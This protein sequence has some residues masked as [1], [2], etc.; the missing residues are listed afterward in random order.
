MWN[1][2]GLNQRSDLLLHFNELL[3]VTIPIAKLLYDKSHC[4]NHNVYNISLHPWKKMATNLSLIYFAYECVHWKKPKNVF[5]PK[6]NI[7]NLKLT[8]YKKKYTRCRGQMAVEDKKVDI[9]RRTSYRQDEARGQTGHIW[10]P[11]AKQV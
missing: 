10:T 1:Y 4:V 11:L 6:M 7:W 9:Q 5:V 8:S 2:G 3:L